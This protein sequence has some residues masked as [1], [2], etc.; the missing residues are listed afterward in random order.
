ME[1]NTN[2]IPNMGTNSF[3]EFDKLTTLKRPNKKKKI[4][5]IIAIILFLALVTFYFLNRQIKQ[6]PPVQT[7]EERITNIE[8]TVEETNQIGV[9][10]AE[11]QLDIMNYNLQE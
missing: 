2:T 8:Q 6:S 7:I 1:E 4:I 3:S 9:P 10:D 11:T 5:I